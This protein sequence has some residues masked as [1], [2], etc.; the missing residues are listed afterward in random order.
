MFFHVP[1]AYF[2]ILFCDIIITSELYMGFPLA[3]KQAHVVCYSR[4]HL[5]GGAIICKPASEASRREEWGEEK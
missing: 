2:V 5:G 3:C 4:E 1:T